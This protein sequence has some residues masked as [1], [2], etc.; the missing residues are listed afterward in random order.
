VAV[1]IDVAMHVASM[2]VRVTAREET[3]GDVGRA[4]G[5]TRNGGQDGA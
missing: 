5:V 4:S 1:A 2:A 3:I